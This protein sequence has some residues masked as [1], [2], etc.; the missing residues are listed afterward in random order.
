MPFDWQAELS[1]PVAIPSKDAPSPMALTSAVAV[2]HSR[3]PL[4][5]LWWHHTVM[6][7]TSSCRSQLFVVIHSPFVLLSRCMKRGSM[8]VREIFEEDWFSTK[9]TNP[10]RRRKLRTSLRN[11]GRLLLLGRYYL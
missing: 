4:L 6:S 10:T 3:V 7:Q 5:K 2:H 8:C 9:E 1:L 11:S